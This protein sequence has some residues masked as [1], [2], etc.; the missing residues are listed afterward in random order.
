[1]GPGDRPGRGAS[2]AA[3]SACSRCLQN[4][5]ASAASRVPK[6]SRPAGPERR[7]PGIGNHLGRV[8]VTA[9]IFLVWA[10]VPGVA[11]L[12]AHQAS[13][14][15][16]GRSSWH[17]VSVSNS[18]R[19]MRLPST[20]GKTAATRP[21]RRPPPRTSTRRPARTPPPSGPPGRAAAHHEPA[22]TTPQPAGPLD[23]ADDLDP[24]VLGGSSRIARCPAP[25]KL[26]PRASTQAARV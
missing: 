17:R 7:S 3:G 19:L 1:M 16:P 12:C 15:I 5:S 14:D 6:K 24:R 4:R 18:S 22:A 13:G 25:H 8:A 11:V 23:H 10:V 26:P 2:R 21:L 20:G 9:R